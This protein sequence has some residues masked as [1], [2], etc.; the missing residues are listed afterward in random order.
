MK[1]QRQSDL[2]L[3]CLSRPFWKATT[4]QNFRIFTVIQCKQPIKYLEHVNLLD[5]KRYLLSCQPIVIVPSCFV[6]KVITALELIDHLCI[7]PIPRIGL[8]HK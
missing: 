6:Y 5:L 3:H 2:G 7:N 4:V 1:F 8:I